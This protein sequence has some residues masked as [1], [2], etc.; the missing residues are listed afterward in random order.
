MNK[1]LIK[2]LLG[3]MALTTLI[4]GKA[5]AEVLES[6]NLNPNKVEI[7]LIAKDEPVISKYDGVKVNLNKGD[8]YF[9]LSDGSW[10]IYKNNKYE[11]QPVNLGDWSYELKDMEELK[12]IT[13]TY[14]MNKNK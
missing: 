12:K 3:A 14:L 2:S 11:F 13:Q 1:L 10:G 7:V 6:K 9:E 5:N 8:F 4:G